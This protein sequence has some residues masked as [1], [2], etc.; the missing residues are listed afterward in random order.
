MNITGKIKK[1]WDWLDGKKR[2]IGIVAGLLL[3]GVNLFFPSLITPDQYS[4]IDGAIDV[5]LFGAITHAGIKTEN[6]KKL[7]ENGKN[8]IQKTAYAARQVISKQH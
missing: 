7:T 1:A 6:G 5:F 8:L 4:F 3:K 2:N